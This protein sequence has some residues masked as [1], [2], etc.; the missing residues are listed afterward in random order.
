MWKFWGKLAK[1]EICN[2]K[3]V[4]YPKV[5]QQLQHLFHSFKTHLLRVK[6]K[7]STNPRSLLILLI[8]YLLLIFFPTNL[9]KH[10][11]FSQSYVLGILIDYLSPAIYLIEILVLLL[12]V[13]SP[14]KR[15][16]RGIFITLIFLFL[17]SLLPSVFVGSFRIIS[18]Y[19]FIEIALW[20][21]FGLWV[22]ENIQW[23]ERGRV[24][25]FLSW[26]V[27]WVSLLALGQFFLQRSVL[28]YWFLG[29][30]F[31]S[32]SMA[33]LAKTGF[34][35]REVL[36]AYGTFPHPNVLGGVLSILLVWFLSVK[37]WRSFLLG[38]GGV[39]VSF[40]RVALLSLLG[41]LAGLSLWAKR[42]SFVVFD[43]Q[44]LISSFSISRRWELLRSSWEMFKNSPLLGMGLGH[45]TI[46]LP[47]FGIPSGLTLFIQ[48]VHNV[49]ALIASE[50]GIFALFIFLLILV[51]ALRET[52][53][54]KRF[55]LTIS[56][57]QLIFLGLF[58]H[59]LYTLPQ[60]LFI[61]LLTL[62]LSF[63]YSDN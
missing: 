47:D 24:F 13:V 53:R 9:A 49:F 52:I 2:N 45:F 40:S 32:P 15:P 59:Y 61:L 50:S 27:F 4:G 11:N 34:L 36:R 42:F 46:N 51:M 16:R 33:G 41:G 12:L 21:F 37:R 3:R 8:F 31:L 30:P 57:L 38:L 48:P 25:L 43:Y 23:K 58:D 29:E 19:R 28:G 10:F 7:F 35:G 62:G 1:V 17:I 22:S 63:S 18:L 54:R 56:L 26:G 55:I 44:G 39:L 20:L 14:W 6:N 60:G 5:S